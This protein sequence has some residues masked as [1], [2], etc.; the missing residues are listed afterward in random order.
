MRLDS[1]GNLGLG[2]TPAASV[3]IKGLQ[4]GNAMFAG[5]NGGSYATANAYFDGANWKYITSN[6]ATLYQQ[7]SSGGTGKHV[8]STAASGTAGNTITFTEAM[9]LNAAG[10]LF[11]G[12]TSQVNAGL[13]SLAF[14]TGFNCGIATKPTNNAGYDAA[15]FFNSST[16]Q[17]G[18][19]ACTT[20]NTS[21]VTSSDY[22]LKENIAPMVNALAKVAQLKPC[23]YNWKLDGAEGQGFIAHELQEV[24]PDAVVGEKDAVDEDGKIKP[25][26]IDTSFLVAT[27]TAAIQEQQALIQSLKARLD[28]ANL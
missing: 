1:S 7:S 20:T 9:T 5:V 13:L 15:R 6:F 10:N 17:I 12:T 19:I 26:G 14:D 16:T 23:T 3:T 18:S 8:W 22:R 27:L 21:Y 25:Q 2:V 24:V 28:A 4:V 11:L